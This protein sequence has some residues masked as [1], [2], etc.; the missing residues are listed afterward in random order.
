[1]GLLI[2]KFGGT[3]V[4]DA[5]RIRFC[6]ARVADSVREGHRVA[7]VVSAMG[8]TTDTLVGLAD[9]ITETPPGREMDQLLATGEQVTIALMSMAL[10]KLGIHAESLTGAQAGFI[11]SGTHT[12]G[13]IETIDTRRLERILGGGGVPV[14]AGFQG[15]S[16]T[17]DVMT[18]GRGGSDTSAVALAAALGADVCEIFTDVDGI[19]T[20]DPR[21][22][23]NAGRIGRISYDE[24]LE[25]ASLGAGV[26]H[27][28]AVE[29]GKKR[30]VPIRV[31]HA[32]RS[33][34][35]TLICEMEPSMEST[36][37]VATVALQKNIGRVTLARIPNQP[38]VQ[39]RIFTQIAEAGIFVDDI[40]QT[41]PEPGVCSVVFTVGKRDLPDVEPVMQAFL[42]DAG[43]GSLHV[44][45][46]LAKVSAV[47]AGMQSQTGVASTMFKA[48][49]DKGI[50]IAN[51]TTSEIK[52]SCLINEADGEQALRAVHDAFELAHKE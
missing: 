6:A 32:Q 27:L 34:P 36:Q 40:I 10:A 33:G 14:V 41:E 13:R 25:A 17:G 39:Q 12:R 52:I 3:S 46:G 16:S 19:Y 44:D 7:V 31:R 11:L 47:G 15:A 30:A 24:M 22:V 2:K 49:A 38:G 37:A 51:I 45:L 43:A 50:L 1:M 23:H 4:G 28:R 8:K 21:I 9:A 20:A 42:K 48:I 18:L 26:M 35:G 5:D 29:V